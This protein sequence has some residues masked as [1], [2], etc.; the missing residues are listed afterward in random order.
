MVSSESDAG[1][2]FSWLAL[3]CST[4]TFVMAS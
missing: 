2:Y 4:H 1:L 3:S